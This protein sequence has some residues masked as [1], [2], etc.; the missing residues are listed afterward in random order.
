MTLLLLREMIIFSL[1][2]LFLLQPTH[3]QPSPSPSQLKSPSISN[4]QL[5]SS[6]SNSFYLPPPSSSPSTIFITLN[7]CHPPSIQA[8]LDYHFDSILIVSNSSDNQNPSPSKLP[9]KARRNLPSI[10]SSTGG[11]SHLIAGFANL[12]LINS[13]GLWISVQAPSQSNHQQLQQ[14]SSSS[15]SFQLG[16]S[17][18]SPIHSVN[19]FPAF[20]FED[21][22]DSNALLTASDSSLFQPHSSSSP[23][24]LQQFL[25]II[26]PTP[27]DLQL[28]LSSS[29]CYLQSL[30]SSTPAH[31]SSSI[32]PSLTT[33]TTGV[34]L[35]SSQ[36]T[37]DLGDHDYRISDQA[38]GLRTQYL[39]S[40]LRPAQ[41]YTAWLFQPTGS[42]DNVPTGR[43][44][45]YVNF[46]T[47][48]SKNCRL[49]FNL[50]FCPSV[51]YSVPASTSQST[52][53]LISFYN[54]TISGNLTNFQTVL[55]TY[56]CNNDT[57]GRYSFVSGCT[58][59]YRAY[60]AWLCAVSMPRCTDSPSPPLPPPPPDS[61]LISPPNQIILS[62]NQ[63]NQS[64]TP[65]L[66]D[67][68]VY[69]Y[70]EVLPCSSVCTLV[71][72]TCP[73]LIGWACPLQSA[74]LHSSYSDLKSLDGIEVMGGQQ[75]QVGQGGFRAGDR[76]GNVFCN[77]LDTDL[78][79]SRMGSS[80]SL[81][82]SS[83]PFV[84]V[85]KII[86]LSIVHLSISSRTLTAWF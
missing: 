35:F 9:V 79:Y 30:L 46:R 76:F 8:P 78:A 80:S 31:P 40:N 5:S 34:G 32:T 54:Q 36:P 14:P 27:S 72:A 48:S 28:G 64:R 1:S 16:I 25:P 47:K 56:P 69:P 13:L 65:S 77:G 57:S 3:S 10:T 71:A 62:R 59:C 81:V 17:S 86:T 42:V 75:T 73:P 20:K 52:P 12:T 85:L 66:T 7:L 11:L 63:P 55:S 37:G 4:F 24:P 51:A 6:S 53:S 33:R 45:P 26:L 2:L 22:D 49:L 39:L 68:L 21:A 38:A 44:W 23:L 61:A 29:S 67:P 19:G 15:W 58:D 84:L 18:T 82:H 83:L 50:P 41:N 60:N 43:L 74:N 70:G